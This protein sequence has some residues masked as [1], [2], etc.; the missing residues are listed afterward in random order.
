MSLPKHVGE[1]ADANSKDDPLKY[2]FKQ[3]YG[4]CIAN[5][6]DLTGI[7]P[8]VDTALEMLTWTK[9][10]EMLVK[11]IPDGMIPNGFAEPD[12]ARVTVLNTLNEVILAGNMMSVD[13]DSSKYKLLVLKNKLLVVQDNATY[14]E[15]QPIEV[16]VGR[17]GLTADWLK[18]QI[19]EVR[20][21]AGDLVNQAVPLYLIP[22]IVMAELR[23]A[24]LSDTVRLRLPDSPTWPFH[25]HIP[26]FNTRNP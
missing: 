17:T 12:G 22:D 8:T 15:T 1:I 7:D 3:L 9:K 16:L 13:S 20:T 24:H 26:S 11:A 19:T 10:F 25:R 21:K 4:W 14:D 6:V 18:K 2:W 23:A 5:N